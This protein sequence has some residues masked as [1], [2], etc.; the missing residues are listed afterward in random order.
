MHSDPDSCHEGGNSM[1]GIYKAYPM[2]ALHVATALLAGSSIT[3][4]SGECEPPRT[5]EVVRIDERSKRL[6]V[7]MDPML[8]DNLSAVSARVREGGAYVRVCKKDWGGD[9]VIS[10]FSDP[11]LAGYKD[12]PALLTFVMD[13][14]WGDSYLGEYDNEKHLLTIHPL[15]PARRREHSGSAVIE[16]RG[17][18]MGFL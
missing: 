14:S 9:W 10:L 1:I 12:D 17:V 16:R 7:R 6:F 8:I 4:A 13:G 5:L 18:R 11:R 2:S 15:D 3:Q